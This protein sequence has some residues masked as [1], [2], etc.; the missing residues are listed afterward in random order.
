MRVRYSEPKID[1]EAKNTI[2]F[3]RY[4]LFSI[5]GGGI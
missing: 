4:S 2:L 3:V 1:V 5:L